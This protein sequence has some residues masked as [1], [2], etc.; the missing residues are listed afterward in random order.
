MEP[1]PVGTIVT[2]HGSV[3]EYWGEYEVD[4]VVDAREHRP[5]LLARKGEAFMDEN[6]PDGVAYSLWPIGVAKK[7]GNRELSLNSVRRGSFTVVGSGDG[8][9]PESTGD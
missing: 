6:Y 8:P 2:Y 4:R 9:D 5:D 3:R 1:L 7:F